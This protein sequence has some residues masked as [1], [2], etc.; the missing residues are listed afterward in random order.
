[1]RLSV[2]HES[3]WGRS[4]PEIRGIVFLSTIGLWF[5]GEVMLAALAAVLFISLNVRQS[6]TGSAS[7]THPELNRAV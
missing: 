4:L 5:A 2:S 1:M 6:Q 3:W 7:E